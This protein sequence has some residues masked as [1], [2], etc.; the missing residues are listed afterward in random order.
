ME[1]TTQEIIARL[2]NMTLALEA[3]GKW[4]EASVLSQ[5]AALIIVQV[6]SVEKLRHASAAEYT[7][8]R[9]VAQFISEQTYD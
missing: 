1:Y 7:D 4:Q 2:M 3:D 8:I 5:A 6:N 9:Q